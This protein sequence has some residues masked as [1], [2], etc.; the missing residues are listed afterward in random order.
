MLWA[1]RLVGVFLCS[2]TVLPE[3]K[4]GRW[5]VRW[6]DFP[7]LQILVLLIAMITTIVIAGLVTGFTG[8][9]YG[10]MIAGGVAAAWQARYL[11]PFSRIGRREVATTTDSDQGERIRIMVSNV[12]F[13]NDHPKVEQVIHLLA[14]ENADVL[15]IVEYEQHWAKR[16]EKLRSQFEH[17]F[18]EVRGEGLGMAVWSHLKIQSA[19][20][21]H[22]ISQRRVSLWLNLMTNNGSETNFVAV[23]PTPPG[24]DDSTGEGRRDSSVRDAE[25]VAVAKEIATG[26][27]KD[28]VVAGDFNDVAWSSTMTLFKRIAGLKDPRIGRAFLGTFMAQVPPCRCPI[29][30]VYV[31]QGFTVGS[32]RRKRIF[33]SDHFAIIAEISLDNARGGVDPESNESDHDEAKRLLEE[34]RIKA[35]ER[36]V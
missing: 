4:T 15:L 34:G 16:L 12:D 19:Q 23:H 32:L 35:S 24:L 25:L 6:W 20:K 18:E 29:D 28:W 8:E 31:S 17:H 7:R 27:E 5:Y 9:H 13:E 3:L 33:G 11:I 1:M 2:V 10:W 14:E 26:Q 30:H 36:N 22:I 21:R